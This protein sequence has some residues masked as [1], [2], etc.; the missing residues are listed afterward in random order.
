MK[1]KSIILS[2]VITLFATTHALAQTNAEM[3]QET[4]AEMKEKFQGLFGFLSADVN[5]VNFANKFAN[6]K[7]ALLDS[8][9]KKLVEKDTINGKP[10]EV[11][12]TNLM[13]ILQGV[14]RAVIIDYGTY[15]D[16]NVWINNKYIDWFIDVYKN[17]ETTR[18]Y[19]VEKPND[20]LSLHK[21]TFYHSLYGDVGKTTLIVD[22]NQTHSTFTI[23]PNF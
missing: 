11:Y 3:K 21:A 2:I 9:K 6:K 19:T 1:I 15:N 12:S 13:F 10:V 22:K 7:E 17:E 8:F 14:D 20:K 16:L 18:Q 23:E 5:N 4:E